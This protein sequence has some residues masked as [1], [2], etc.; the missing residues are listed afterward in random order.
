MAG[1]GQVKKGALIAVISDE[2]CLF[3]RLHLQ[4]TLCSPQFSCQMSLPTHAREERWLM[5]R[6]PCV[7]RS[8]RSAQDTV[9][10]FLLG[11][12]GE[13]NIKREGNFLIVNKGAP[14]VLGLGGS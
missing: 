7:P 11:G 4:E 5:M 2:V 9:T 10:G 1:K 3:V 12:I 8:P 6:K 14:Q 13:M